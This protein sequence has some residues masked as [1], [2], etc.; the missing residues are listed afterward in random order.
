MQRNQVVN[1]QL[2]L[3]CKGIT[4]NK[5]IPFLEE[6]ATKTHTEWQFL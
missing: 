1:N 2:N 3:I 4:E 5:V 6:I